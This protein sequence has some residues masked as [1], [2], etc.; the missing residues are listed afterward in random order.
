MYQYEKTLTMI[1][2]ASIKPGKYVIHRNEE[3]LKSHFDGFFRE[4][5][6]WKPITV[7]KP[8]TVE[9]AAV[10]AAAAAAAA[11]FQSS[12]NSIMRVFHF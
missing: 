4:D 12:V 11:A 6:F 10:A 8:P 7:W 9:A 1:S 5:F 2:S 3:R